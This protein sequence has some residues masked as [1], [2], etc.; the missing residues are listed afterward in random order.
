M[1]QEKCVCTIGRSLRRV[2]MAYRGGVP[3]TDCWLE[4]S[5]TA[6]GEV[7]LSLLTGQGDR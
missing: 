2:G 4:G 5:H 6:N 1:P 3:L 7:F